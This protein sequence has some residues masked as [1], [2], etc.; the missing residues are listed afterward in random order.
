M[1]FTLKGGVSFTHKSDRVKGIDFHPTEPWVLTTLYS[2]KIEIW[3]YE[4]ETE[5]RSIQVTETP[6]RAGRFI[7]RKNWVIVGC[8]DFRIRVYNYNTGEKIAD[9]E[10]HPDYIRSIAVHPTKP[11]I[12]SASD[13]M[14]IKLWNWEKQWDL[15]QTF[16]GHEHFV[17]CVAFNPKDPTT[18]ASACL[19]RTVKVWS[20]GQSTP[21]FTLNTGQEKGV[22]YVDYYPLP[23]KPYLVTASDD[24]TVKIWDYQTKSCV[25][26]L[27]KHTAN[28]SFAIFHPSLPV[29]VS[30]S[31]D[32][33]VIAWNSSTY[34]HEEIANMGME[35]AW[36][37]AT[38]PTGKK[39]YIAVGFDNGF[40]IISLASDEPIM[41]LDP[42]GKLVWAG[43][44]N[45][46]ASDIFTAAIRG[47]EEVEEGE[48]LALQTKE[49]GSVDTLP[50]KLIHS[51]NGRFVAVLGDSEYV[52]YTAL[53][54]RNKSFG[55]ASAFVWGPDS[56]SYA[57][58]QRGKILYYK[59]F[60]LVQSVTY[61]GIFAYEL[62]AGP[63]LGVIG[64]RSGLMYEP[65]GFYFYEWET[66]NFVATI[67]VHPSEVIWSDSGELLMIVEATGR[68]NN[69]SKEPP[70]EPKSYSLMFN[71]EIYETA[72]Q[73]NTVDAEEGVVDAFEV[74]D[75]LDENI[76]SG[77]W[78]GDVFIYTTSSNRLNY[79]VGGKTYNLNHYTKEMYL[80]GYMARDNSVYLAD[81]EIHIYSHKVSLE[82]LEFQ[83]LA[84]R[85]E[86]EEAM[87]SVLPNLKD[88]DSLVKLARFLE[89][90]EHYE[91]ALQVSP[92]SDQKFDLALKLGDLTLAHD[93]LTTD[94]NELKWRSLGDL[95]LSKFNFKLA[96][97]SYTNAHDLESLFLLYSSFNNK[98]E[99]SK[100]AQEA[101][102]EGKYNLAFNCYWVSGDIESIKNLL[103]KTERLSEAAIFSHTYGLNSDEVDD[104]VKQWKEK[105]VLE[106]KES[107]AERI[108][109][110]SSPTEAPLIDIDSTTTS[111][112]I[113]NEEEELVDLESE[114]EEK[115][116]QGEQGE[117]EE[118]VHVEEEEAVQE[119]TDL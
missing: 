15:Q 105:L 109:T 55:E 70:K 14:T 9:F 46:A 26:T 24:H 58:I 102:N 3:N 112:A 27:S 108:K 82:V 18:F 43:G 8:D 50:E 7:A 10:A 57:V 100:L 52:I 92:D 77:K 73:N 34:R 67:N 61:G 38:H 84:L 71:K 65:T 2:G 104:I 13:D 98:N 119:K 110:N 97:E 51:P 35:R 80:L 74:I 37:V 106:G 41:S 69:D 45:A 60:K 83:T 49:L 107:I 29:I 4:T 101:E 90:Q 19:D 96:I 16:Q 76:I 28:V 115:Q 42:V 93:L 85:G 81:R 99:L 56:N 89:N 68:E 40:K 32:G 72:L 94:D 64:T 62:F 117:E 23:D 116:Q 113:E 63:L 22:N 36:C 59:N 95:G 47:T 39:N 75:E 118:A 48:P 78:V 12:L 54:W 114:E 1:K 79:F 87:T 5:V 111:V 31:E 25:A 86:L 21:N 20:L 17:M 33:Q 44:K 6:V 88:K 66:G 91:E 30:G 53:A 11:Y 103:I